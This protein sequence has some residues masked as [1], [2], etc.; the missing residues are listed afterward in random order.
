MAYNIIG[1]KMS[2]EEFKEFIRKNPKLIDYVKKEKMTWQQFYE[3]YDLYGADHQIWD[4]Y[5]KSQKEETKIAA[6][7]TLA[8]LIKRVD[9]DS[10]QNGVNN[11]QR[12]LGLFQDI[13]NNKTTKEKQKPR[14]LYKHFED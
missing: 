12:I 6:A 8:D 9:L 2:K 14:P 7:V 11:M 10:I 13:G 3:M 1:D 5:L 4:D